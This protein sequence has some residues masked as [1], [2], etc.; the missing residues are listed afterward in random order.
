MSDPSLYINRELSWLHFNRRVLDEAIRQDQHPL[1]ERVKFIAIFSSNLDEFFMIRVAGIEKQVEAGIRK[2]TID[3]LTPSEQLERI[4]AEV[5]EQLKLRNTC[6]YGDILPALAAEGITFVHFADLPEKEQA[7][8]N[9]W[10]RKEIYPVLTPLA[11]DTGHPFPFMSNL[12]LNLAIELDEVEH[13]NLKFARVKVPSVLPRLLKLNDIEGLGNDPSCMRFLWIE[14]LI[15]QNLGLLFPTMKIVQS[16]QF[17]IIRNADIEI[18][19]DEAGDLLQTI[20]KG[21]RSRRYGNVVRLDISPEMPDFVRQLLINNL[22]IEE[23][24]VYE[25]DGA[26]GMSC[27]MELLDIDRPSL[28]DEPFIPFNMFE[29]QR[30]GDIFS[31]ISSGDLLFYHPYDSFKPVVDFIDRAASDPDVLSIKQTLYRVGSNSP[32]VKALMKAAESGK[33]VAVLVELK[34]RFDEENNIGWARALEDVGAHVIY[35]LPGLKT[36]AKLTLVVRREPQGLKRYLHLGTGNYNPST[37]KLYTDYSFFTDDEL[38]AGEVSELFNALTGYFRYTGYR[39]L[40]VSPINTRK[41]IIEMIEREIALARKSSGGRIIMKMNSLVDPATIQALYRASRAGVQIDLVVRGICCLKP[42]I[43][44]VS[45]NIRVISIIGRYLEH[46]RAYYFANGGSPELYLGSADIMPRN[47]D[48]RVET[49]FPVFDP[50]LVER[51]R[52]DLELQLSDNL[53]AWKIGPDG[54]W[55]LVRNDAPKVNSQER[56]MKRRTQKKKTTGIKGRLGLN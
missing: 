28:K 54:N 40:L 10:F 1:I 30:N 35:G 4:R 25:I 32:I 16:H 21:V 50:S 29:E 23:K 9:A 37:G 36:H 39:F 43:P 14:E 56:F 48:D 8:L 11:F 46:S 6:L 18:E 47:L 42:G 51:V 44:G 15:Q 38:L 52:N 34:A 27:L 49:L 53:K 13:G 19:E 17:R 7:V 26:L 3:G 20:E 55:T 45:E 12:S 2:K 24:N 31:A 22:E 33:Q 5:I 41:R